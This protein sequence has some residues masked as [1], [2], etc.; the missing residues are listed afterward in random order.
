[1]N[2]NDCA[3]A[4]EAWVNEVLPQLAASRHFL[5]GQKTQLPDVLVDVAEKRLVLGDDRFPF[6]Q[7]QQAW[8]RVFELELLFMVEHHGGSADQDEQE[9]LRLYGASLEGS[10]MENATLG[11]RVQMASPN[12]I[13]NY[14]LP[15]VQYADGTRGRQL[16]VNMAVAELA[17]VEASG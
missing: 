12:A 2:E 3:L 16:V 11:D 5:S 9:E 7:I 13:F 6:A 1:M 10:L 15:F 14:R 17:P 4:V 8:L